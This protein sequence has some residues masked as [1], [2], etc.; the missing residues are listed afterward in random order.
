MSTTIRIAR[1][2][3]RV[4]A[5]GGRGLPGFLLGTAP[6]AMPGTLGSLKFQLNGT[7]IFCMARVSTWWPRRVLERRGPERWSASN[8]VWNGGHCPAWPWGRFA[9]TSEY[10]AVPAPLKPVAVRQPFPRAWAAKTGTPSPAPPHKA[11]TAP[12]TSPPRSAC[13]NS[14]APVPG[15]C[16]ARRP[17]AAT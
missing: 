2:R 5:S 12:A 15:R 3:G 11:T 6:N 1:I 10:Q 9:V 13:P 16:P 4:N 14:A 7:S 8:S 17:T